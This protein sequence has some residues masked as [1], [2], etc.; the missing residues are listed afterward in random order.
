ME[1]HFICFPVRTEV[2]LH[3][4]ALVL[5]NDEGS[6]LVRT[7]CVGWFARNCHRE[8]F[9]AVL[10]HDNSYGSVAVRADAALTEGRI[11]A[12]AGRSAGEDNLFDEGIER[13]GQTRNVSFRIGGK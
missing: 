13:S 7:Q 3:P 12:I 4:E 9:V 2:E 11:R 6:G 8:L 10:H 5:G 1:D